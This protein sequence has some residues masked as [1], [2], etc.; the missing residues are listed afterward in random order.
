MPISEEKTVRPTTVL[1]FLGLEIDSIA[2]QVRIPI[3]KVNEIVQLIHTFLSK[4]S[5]TLREMQS[6]L[7]S[8]NFMCRA[9]VPGRPFCRRLIDV[10]CGIKCPHYH[11][12]ISSGVR[13]DLTTWLQFF[14]SFNGISVFQER[15]W[16]TNEDV[17]LYTDSSAAVGNGFGAYCQGNWTFGVWPDSWRR[18]GI[19]D[20]ITTLEYFPI[21]VA[22]HVWGERLR[23][24]RVLFRCDNQAVVHILNTQTSKDCTIMILVREL[25]LRCLH[26]NLSVKAEHIPGASNGITDSLSRLQMDRFRRLAPDAQPHSDPVPSYLWEIFSKERGD[27]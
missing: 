18:L 4:K 3:E 27:S 6:L 8:L 16:L 2:M 21:L 23:N 1:V 5:V 7:G 12:R 26:L 14:Q 9:I 15:F 20:S 13:K 19:T 22:V 17:C 24:K 25:T 10:T 11:I